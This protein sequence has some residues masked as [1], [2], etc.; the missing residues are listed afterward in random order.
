[1][2]LVTGGRDDIFHLVSSTE[3]LVEG[4]TAWMS[5]G[6]LPVAMNGLRGVSFD[7]NIFVTGN[8]SIQQKYFSYV[9]PDITG[10]SSDGNSYQ[11]SILQ[12]NPD[13]GSWTQVGQLQESR[14]DHGASVVDIDNFINFCK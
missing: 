7:N 10:G 12:F 14:Y 3:V 11:D 6:E 8:I 5:A 1:M 9:F 2:Y 4:T 13:D